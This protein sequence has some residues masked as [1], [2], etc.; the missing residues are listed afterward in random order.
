MTAPTARIDTVL[1]KGMHAD[2]DERYQSASALTTAAASALGLSAPPPP[3]VAPQPPPIAPTPP[4]TPT[5]PVPLPAAQAGSRS[6]WR[7]HLVAIT[8]AVSVVAVAVAVPLIVLTGERSGVVPALLTSAEVDSIM[9]TGNLVLIDRID[10]GLDQFGATIPAEC[11]T[12]GTFAGTSTYDGFPVTSIRT[13]LITETGNN[14]THSVWQSVVAM[15]SPSDAKGYLASE[16]RDWTI[17]KG[18]PFAVLSSQLVMKTLDSSDDLLVAGVTSADGT[19]QCQR[20]TAAA[21]N[22]IIETVACGAAISD[23]GR[24]LAAELVARAG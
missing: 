19:Q 13:A 9:G 8:S 6:W 20:V 21:H 10:H 12:V 15:A 24:A 1:A 22:L 23:E 17:C 5:D 18:R 4:S 11:T 2:P 16:S 3:P 7:R 14:P